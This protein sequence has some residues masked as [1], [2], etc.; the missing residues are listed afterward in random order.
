M[1]LYVLTHN[2]EVDDRL[3]VEPTELFT[4]TDSR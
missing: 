4:V 3:N 1:A 2:G